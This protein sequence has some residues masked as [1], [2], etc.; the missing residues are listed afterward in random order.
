M[1]KSFIVIVF[2]LA[3]VLTAA[4]AHAQVLIIAHPGVKASEVS[5]NDVRDIFSGASKNLSG[6]NVV[7]ALLKSGNT[8]D[9]FLTQYVG[10]NDSAFRA[11]WR[12][13]V[14]AGEAAMPKTLDSEAAMVEHVAHTPGAVGYIAK[15]TAHEG[16]KVLTIK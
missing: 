2:A 4:A 13:M 16:V 11:T 6:S 5:K 15:A 14:F 1:N 8:H 10:K 7:P 12:S 9:S 3:V